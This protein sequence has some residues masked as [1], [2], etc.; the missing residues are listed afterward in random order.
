MKFV[1]LLFFILFSLLILISSHSQGA[2]LA[3]P[4]YRHDI[5]EKSRRL[6][7]NNYIFPNR[8]EECFPSLRTKLDTY[9]DPMNL[10]VFIKTFSADLKKIC[11]DNH[12]SISRRN[13]SANQN[14]A[15]PQAEA[16]NGIE[17]KIA[18]NFGIVEA[19]VMEGNIGY[20]KTTFFRD[21][22]N[23]TKALVT[24]LNLVSSTQA[25]IIDL[26][27]NRGGQPAMVALLASHFFNK[28]THLNT[29]YSRGSNRGFELWTSRNIPGPNLSDMPLYILTSKRTG[30]AAEGFSYHMKHLDRATLVGTKTYGAANPGGFYNLDKD[31]QIFIS[32]G[33]PVNPITKANWEGVGVTPQV[34]VPEEQALNKAI[35]M[36]NNP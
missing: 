22:I 19:K 5:A 6:I 3:D 14:S 1:S 20:V 25:I 33:R 31:L 8:A 30:S 11:Q 35:N 32:N 21:P 18:D 15:T 2:T 10:D 34:Q 13:Q 16:S 26:R 24:A 12:F 7:R 36:I 17:N 4:E 28:P 23:A 29:F 9:A 27:E